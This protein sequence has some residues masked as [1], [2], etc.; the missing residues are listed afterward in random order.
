MITGVLISVSLALVVSSYEYSRGRAAFD[1]DCVVL[2]SAIQREIGTALADV[3][4]VADLYRSSTL[5]EHREFESFARNIL[6]RHPSIKA[7]EW[8]PRVFDAERGAFETTACDPAGQPL[9]ISE[10]GSDGTLQSASSRP[11]YFPVHYV[12]PFEPNIAAFGY[13]LASELSR[14]ETL[15]M[16]IKTGN[17]TASPPITLVQSQDSGPGFI[18]FNPMYSRTASGGEG[19]DWLAATDGLV[20]GV[21]L[22]S[23]LVNAALAGLEVDWVNIA[24]HDHG[25]VDHLEPVFSQQL[26]GDAKDSLEFRKEWPVAGRIW[27]ARFSIDKTHLLASRTV[28]PSAVLALGLLLTGLLGFNMAMSALHAHNRELAVEQTAAALRE[29]TLLEGVLERINDGIRVGEILTFIYRSFGDIIP[30][31]RMGLALVEDEGQTLRSVW[32]RSRVGEVLL[33]D[34][35]AAPFAGSSLQEV[36]ESRR[37]RVINDLAAYLNEHPRSGSTRLMVQEGMRSSLTCPLIVH[38]KPVG[39]LFFNSTCPGIYAGRHVDS[40]VR[41]ARHLSAT[42]EKGRLY[43]VLAKEEQQLNAEL[44]EAAA[45]VESL[46][47]KP[48]EGKKVS[49]RWQFLPSTRLGGDAF[50]YFWLDDDHLVIHLLDVC[51]HGVGAALLSVSVMNVLRTRSLPDTDF[52]KPDAVLR[53]LNEAFA[54]EKHHNLYFTMWYGVYQPSTGTLTYASG[55]H[56]PALL[57]KGLDRASARP[58][59]LHTCGPVVGGMPEASYTAKQVQLDTYN[60]LYVFSDGAYEIAR[61]DGSMMNV[62]EL[63]EQLVDADRA[64]AAPVETTVQRLR[65]VIGGRAFEDDLSLLQVSFERGSARAVS[66][67]RFATAI[68]QD[69]LQAGSAVLT[70]AELPTEICGNQ[71]RQFGPEL[72]VDALRAD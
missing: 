22:I 5:V 41:V 27:Q 34:G 53:A 2:A 9:M 62:G 71:Q 45:Y 1:R 12:V 54:M 6:A 70:C 20:V 61:P 39:F 37:P 13:D 56:P 40:F 25:D 60:S 30:F 55:G 33:P 16:A 52:R 72:G 58:E 3:E 17:Q 15:R 36:F 11:V 51:S 46:L 8:A 63:T 64:G 14:A 50:D 59:Q 47:P 10:L 43:D 19:A 42:I 67:E 66:S 26:S 18:V 38:N 4:S 32:S 29:M 57:L 49:A 69:V 23:E 35:Y 68:Q 28:S 65:S 21:F 48:L 7:L 24:I 31:D 44:T